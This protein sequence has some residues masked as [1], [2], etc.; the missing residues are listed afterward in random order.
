MMESA[1]AQVARSKVLQENFFKWVEKNKNTATISET[2]IL[3]GKLEDAVGSSPTICP[4][5]LVTVTG[6]EYYERYSTITL[7]RQIN[8]FMCNKDIS[9]DNTLEVIE[10][11]LKVWLQEI[12]KF[13][14][15]Y[16]DW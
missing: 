9:Q 15:F 2:L 1:E 12:G 14:K 6:T 5:D 11:L 13:V 3:L 7:S 16:H 8:D 4:E 10:P